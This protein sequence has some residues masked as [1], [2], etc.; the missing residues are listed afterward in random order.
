MIFSLKEKCWSAVSVYHRS[1]FLRL[2]A[3]GLFSLS[4]TKTQKNIAKVL[5]VTEN[6]NVTLHCVTLIYVFIVLL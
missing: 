4:T 6:C 5:I 3:S 2:V 1:A